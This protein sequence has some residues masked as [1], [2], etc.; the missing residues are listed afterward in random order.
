MTRMNGYERVMAAMDLQE[1]D[2]VPL[3]EFFID[4]RVYKALL[5]SATNQTPLAGS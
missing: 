2:R 5:P 3:V 4:P 1:P